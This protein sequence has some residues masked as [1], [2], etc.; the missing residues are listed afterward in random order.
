[1]KKVLILRTFHFNNAEARLNISP[2]LKE[3]GD[4]IKKL[5][6]PLKEANIYCELLDVE[7]D[8]SRLTAIQNIIKDHKIEKSS[9]LDSRKL[10]VIPS[11]LYRLETIADLYKKGEYDKI[12][13]V[14]S[15]IIFNENINEFIYKSIYLTSLVGSHIYIPS[16]SEILLNKMDPANSMMALS[17]DIVESYINAIKKLIGQ[18]YDSA[19]MPQSLCDYTDKILNT[20]GFQWDSLGSELLQNYINDGV[21][22]QFIKFPVGVTNNSVIKSVE[23]TGN[24]SYRELLAR[25]ERISQG[26]ICG[27][28][29]SF[30]GLGK[31]YESIIN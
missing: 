26:K 11:D 16:S 13:Y 31:I 19:L 4:R 12:I 20:T 29:T 2:R 25:A 24:W 9:D 22:K 21:V 10:D 5:V 3:N 30:V 7:V 14:D 17:W 1:M 23:S 15:D 8:L 18:E 28:N 6:E 27:I